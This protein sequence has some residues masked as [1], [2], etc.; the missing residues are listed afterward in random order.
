MVPSQGGRFSRA[1]GIPRVLCVEW[2]DPLYL[3]GH[4]VPELVLAAGAEDVGAEPGAHSA[5]RSWAEAERLMPDLVVVMLCGFG[6][7]RAEMELAALADPVALRL[8]G[9]VPTC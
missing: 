7:A 8:L 5:R 4:W 2:L 6:L 1:V 9:S 3:A